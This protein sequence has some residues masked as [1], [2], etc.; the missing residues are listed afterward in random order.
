MQNEVDGVVAVTVKVLLKTSLQISKELYQT[1]GRL[2]KIWMLQKNETCVNSQ[3]SHPFLICTCV[4]LQ[5]RRK[6][7]HNYYP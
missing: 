2:I 5:I 4:C 7:L 3:I 1:T 6:F